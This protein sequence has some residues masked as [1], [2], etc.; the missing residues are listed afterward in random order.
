MEKIWLALN[1]TLIAGLATGLGGCLALFVKQ[2]QLR[3]LAVSM[4][5][6]AGVMLYVSFVEIFKKSELLLV[7]AYGASLGHWMNF[8]FF[9]LG[10]AL[11]HLV[12][13]LLPI[14]HGDAHQA[15]D[16]PPSGPRRSEH[17]NPS[18]A[19]NRMGIVTAIAI[20]IHNLPEG[21]GTFLATL[22][23]PTLGLMIA[24]AIALHNIPEGI[25]VAIPIFYAT[26]S[27]TMALVYSLVSGLAEP[28][29]ALL[30]LGILKLVAHD[31]AALVAPLWMGSFFAGV[32]GIMVYISLSELLPTSHRYGEGNDSLWGLLGGMSLM[33]ISLNLL[34]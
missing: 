7:Q 1:V 14:P 6:S 23:D 16:H 19:L 29:G 34:K 5:F 28:I 30:V 18:A 12:E 33:G 25:S 2:T 8:T 24:L 15:K 10:I 20:G 31:S 26:G 32:A 9:F 3:F 13:R 17:A 27:R 22:D 21:G 4:G 11:I